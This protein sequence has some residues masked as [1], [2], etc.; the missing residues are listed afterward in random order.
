MDTSNTNT[1][2]NNEETIRNRAVFSALAAQYPTAGCELHFGSV[3]QLLVAVILSAQCTDKRVNMV[4]PA[5]FAACPNPQA[6]LDLGQ[7]KLEKMIFSCGFFRSKAKNI[8]LASQ[9]LIDHYGGEVPSTME[10]LIKLP[11]VGRKT[12]NVVL[13]VAFSMPTVAVD[14]HV[15]RVSHR[16][17]FSQGNTPDKVEKDLLQLFSGDMLGLLHHLLIFHGRYCCHSQKPNC[18]NCPVEKHCTYDGKNF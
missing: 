10:E 5:L 15:F 3:F 17:G 2:T 16:L 7:E 18:G 9:F 6:F 1:K 14:T 12:A 8:L 4:T 13:S 11:G